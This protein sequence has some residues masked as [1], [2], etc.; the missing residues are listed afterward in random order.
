MVGLV[1]LL[2]AV[3]Y[4]SLPISASTN[5]QI[6]S[7]PKWWIVLTLVPCIIALAAGLLLLLGRWQFAEAWFPD[8]DNVSSSLSGPEVVRVGL[9]LIGAWLLFGAAPSLLSVIIT[10]AYAFMQASG[11][12][13]AAAARSTQLPSL[14]MSLINPIATFI[15][16]WALI[17][18]SSR[19]SNRFM[20]SRDQPEKPDI[21]PSTDHC[22][23]C[24]AEYDSAD[25][26]G[27]LSPALCPQC[28]QPLGLPNA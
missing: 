21:P 10:T 1:F 12:V 6:A 27:G 22:P 26:E 3:G 19:I 5:S 7:I 11:L 23:S 25:Y 4:L 14:G 2:A 8:D 20:S 24:G 16:G 15:V 17:A 13:G 9:V 18:N 28:K